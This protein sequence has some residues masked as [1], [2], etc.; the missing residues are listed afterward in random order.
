MRVSA[1]CLYRS[2]IW[3]SCLV[4]QLCCAL[5]SQEGSDSSSIED[6]EGE[7][8]GKVGNGDTET[9]MGS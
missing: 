1:N 9:G 7:D 5:G 8:S 4:S 6:Y 3:C 2:S